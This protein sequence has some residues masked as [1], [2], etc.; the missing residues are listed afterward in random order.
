M[1]TIA[2]A[3][4]RVFGLA[5]ALMFVL[6]MGTAQAQTA[7]FIRVVTAQGALDGASKDPAHLKWIPVASVVAADLN[8]DAMADRESSAPSVS[9]ITV[10]REHG[11]GMATGKSANIGSQSSGADAGKASNDQKG[12]NSTSGAVDRGISS[13][14]GGS[15]DRT[16]LTPRDASSGMATGKRMHKP[17]TITKEIDKASPLLAR[18]AASG[19]PVPEVD[20]ELPQ[21]G[22]MRRYVLQNVMVSSIQSVGGGDRPMESITFTYQKIEMK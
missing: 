5:T 12:Q 11:S 17:F 21:G 13:P 22:A 3:R 7:G 2:T 8:G 14:T 10:A 20:V 1:K 6:G 9:E 19:T 18:L 4:L 15:S 16:A